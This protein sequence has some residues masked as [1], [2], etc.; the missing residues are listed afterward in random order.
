MKVKFRQQYKGGTYQINLLPNLDL[1][2]QDG[3]DAQMV[4]FG[5][6]FWIVEV[7]W[8]KDTKNVV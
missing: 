4:S 2:W 3:H 8:G 6:L 5:W 1:F 7:W